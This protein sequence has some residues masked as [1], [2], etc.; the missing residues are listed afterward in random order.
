MKLLILVIILFALTADVQAFH[1]D[2]LASWY[3]HEIGGNKTANGE[4]W[5]PHGF[6]CATWAYPFGTW[7][8]V[9]CIKTGKVVLVRVNDRGPNRKLHRILDVSQGAAA[10]LGILKIGVAKVKIEE[11]R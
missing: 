9:R 3:G 11:V 8:R 2:G 6:T 7:L 1:T 4:R 10:Q 5:N